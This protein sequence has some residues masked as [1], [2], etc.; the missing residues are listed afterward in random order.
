M[1]EAAKRMCPFK[2]SQR[3]REVKKRSTNQGNGVPIEERE[4][5]LKKWNANWRKE[6][7]TEKTKSK[8]TC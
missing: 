3:K 8:E 7:P 4:R 5:Q 2:G 6:I 1:V